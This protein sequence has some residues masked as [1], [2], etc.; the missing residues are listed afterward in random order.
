MELNSSGASGIGVVDEWQTGI[1]KKVV[2]GEQSVLCGGLTGLIR[3]ERVLAS[4]PNCLGGGWRWGSSEN[5]PDVFTFAALPRLDFQ[6]LTLPS[7]PGVAR[8]LKERCMLDREARLQKRE[9]VLNRN[10]EPLGPP[11]SPS[12]KTSGGG[13]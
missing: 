6:S 1:R 5:A 3:N 11:P 8:A 13:S 2:E 4:S 10:W 9:A 7:S 12:P